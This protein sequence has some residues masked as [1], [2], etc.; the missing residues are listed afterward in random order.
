MRRQEE[1][2]PMRGNPQDRTRLT[3]SPV[4]HPA[5]WLLPGKPVTKPPG[6]ARA[7]A[8]A[9]LRTFL[10]RHRALALLLFAAALCIKAA[11]PAGVMVGSERKVLTIE[12]CA[13]TLGTHLTRQIAVPVS[14]KAEGDVDGKAGTHKS[15][16]TCPFG[17]LAMGSLGGADVALLAAALAFVMAL[18][19]APRAEPTVSAPARLRPP[20]RAPPALA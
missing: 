2:L 1:W 9:V 10:L 4:I 17:A 11:V 14:G 16:T 18:G 13:D 20:L 5:D 12:I 3:G 15:D 7:P 8:M 6:E 19:L